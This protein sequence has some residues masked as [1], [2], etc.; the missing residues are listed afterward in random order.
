MRTLSLCFNIILTEK[1]LFIVSHM[2]C[3]IRIFDG[4]NVNI[5]NDVSRV[6]LYRCP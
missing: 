6:K 5:K 1:R 4:N 3:S 2:F